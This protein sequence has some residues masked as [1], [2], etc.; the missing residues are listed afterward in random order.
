ME[1]GLGI[2]E[3]GLGIMEVGP[4][5]RRLVGNHGDWMGTTCTRI[6]QKSSFIL[7]CLDTE[8]TMANV[9]LSNNTL[10]R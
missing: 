7:P 2:I 5:S 10:Q 3:V 1:V 9:I 8:T 6:D 4:E